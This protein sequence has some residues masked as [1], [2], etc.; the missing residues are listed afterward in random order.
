M[1]LA[2]VHIIFIWNFAMTNIKAA[3][4]VDGGG[5]TLYLPQSC[6]KWISVIHFWGFV[7]NLSQR[8]KPRGLH[9]NLIKADQ[10]Y[11]GIA[12]PP[13]SA[14]PRTSIPNWHTELHFTA[15]APKGDTEP[16]Q[17]SSSISKLVGKKWMKPNQQE[18]I[19][20]I[21]PKHSG[22]S[23]RTQTAWR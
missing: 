15:L 14:F 9:R 16:F 4:R 3:R 20:F 23:A 18:L 10:Y 17:R 2:K 21:Q 19:H 11:I 6:R 12:L 13:V 7:S 1:K 22:S 5:T 8:C